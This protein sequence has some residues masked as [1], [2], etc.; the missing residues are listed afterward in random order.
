MVSDPEPNIPECDIKW[1]LGNTAANETSRDDGI[2]AEL[3]KILKDDVIEILHS[4]CQQILK[5]K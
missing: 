1:P 2:P 3:F 4:I 5:T